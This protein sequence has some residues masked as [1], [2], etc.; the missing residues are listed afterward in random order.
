MKEY[1]ITAQVIDT[2]SNPK[3]TLLMNEVVQSTNKDSAKDLFTLN[4]LVD[5]IVVMK[6]LSIEE[7]N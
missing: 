5:D 1:N 2:C 7:I 6:I 3:Q 4:L